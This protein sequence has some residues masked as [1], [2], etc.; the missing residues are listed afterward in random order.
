MKE[1]VIMNGF[2]GIDENDFNRKIMENV[3]PLAILKGLK[4]LKVNDEKGIVP[5]RKRTSV[6]EKVDMIKKEMEY[7]E[8]LRKKVESRAVEKIVVDEVAYEANIEKIVLV[9]EVNEFIFQQRSEDTGKSY[10]NAISKFFEWAGKNKI[11]NVLTID[12]REVDSYMHYLQKN[13][14]QEQQ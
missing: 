1:G 8:D 11:Q 13:I 5:V 7:D 10:K 6:N 3:N 9:Y 4:G 2:I 12:V 14:H